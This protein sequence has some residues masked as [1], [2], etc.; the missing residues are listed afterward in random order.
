MN[1]ELYRSTMENHW[2][3]NLGQVKAEGMDDNWLLFAETM[4]RIIIDNQDKSRSVAHIVPM[5]TGE[6]KTQGSIVYCSIL[7]VDVKAMMVVRLNDDASQ[8]AEQI[9]NLGGNAVAY[10]SSVH[11]EINDAA[12]YQT[13]VV[14]H[15]FFKRNGYKNNEKWQTLSV[16]RDLFIIDEALHSVNSISISRRELDF[17]RHTAKSLQQSD[18]LSMTEKLINTIDEIKASSLD[19][20]VKLVRLDQKIEFSKELIDEVFSRFT[21]EQK[22]LVTRENIYQV[23]LSILDELIDILKSSP[24][25]NAVSCRSRYIKQHH[26]E[27]FYRKEDI[28][29]AEGLKTIMGTGAFASKKRESITG[30]KEIVPGGVSFAVLDATAP[31]NAIYSLQNKYKGDVYTVPVS[32]TRNYDGFT[33]KCGRTLTGNGSLDKDSIHQMCNSI[34][35]EFEPGD[36]ILFVTH[37]V[38]KSFIST[39]REVSGIVDVEMAIEHYGNITG[40]NNWRDYNKV[41]LIGL[42]HKN[43]E[44]YQSLNIVK[45]CEELAYQSEGKQNHTQIEYTDLAS[46]MVQATARIRVRNIINAEG[47]CLP[48]KAYITMN[49]MKSLYSTLED[50]LLKQFPGAEITEWELPETIAKAEQLPKGYESTLEYLQDRLTIVG[51]D[52]DIYEP[53]DVLDINRESYRR[54]ITNKI[55]LEQV[56]HLGF[57]IQECKVR[58]KRGRMK[59]RPSKF[60]VRVTEDVTDWD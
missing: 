15:E 59:K 60:I 49:P 32:R 29:L 13:V 4:N 47:G 46:D 23:N 44:F 1:P 25:T 24:L 48:A 26:L 45:T 20:F 58:D 3:H 37:K 16:D 10:N 5:A 21:D 34:A 27:S 7:P 39:W 9:N 43:T 18:A 33:I 17:L 42:P 28:A 38:N 2:I 41:A 36:K 40:K 14:S 55:F 31:V 11:I 53:R 19:G 6:S 30:V 57:E 54:L 52:I 35:K 51:A 12:E 22:K 8:I 56:K 50:S